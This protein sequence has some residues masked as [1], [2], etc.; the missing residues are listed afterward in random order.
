ML[1]VPVVHLSPPDRFRPARPARPARLV[2]LVLILVFVTTLTALGSDPT[3]ALGL[4]LAAA[5]ALSRLDLGA[6][7][8]EDGR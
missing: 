3:L 4:A 2:V 8:I 6:A 1:H 5:T 7:Q